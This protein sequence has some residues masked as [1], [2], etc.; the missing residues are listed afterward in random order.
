MKKARDDV[1]A[2]EASRIKREGRPPSS[3]NLAGCCSFAARA[4]AAT[5]ISVCAIVYVAP[6]PAIPHRTQEEARPLR[7]YCERILNYFR[8]QKLL[9]AGVGGLNNKAKSL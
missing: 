9:S 2:K 8:A 6:D 7:H 1:R 4:S 5:G 3:G